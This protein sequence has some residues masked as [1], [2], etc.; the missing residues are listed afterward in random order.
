VRHGRT[1][2]SEGLDGIAFID[3]SGQIAWEGLLVCG[4]ELATNTDANVR[5]FSID[6]LNVE[7]YPRRHAPI[8]PE[9]V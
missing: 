2:N 3:G 9:K 1:S 5:T 4:D 7:I 6:R 8:D